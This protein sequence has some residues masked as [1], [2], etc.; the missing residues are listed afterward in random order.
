MT[1]ILFGGEEYYPWGG[2]FDAIA[3]YDSAL[4]AP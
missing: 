1:A 4:E 2:G 3:V